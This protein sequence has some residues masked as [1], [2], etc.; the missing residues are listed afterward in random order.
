MRLFKSDNNE[1]ITSHLQQE[2]V[3]LLKQ[4]YSEESNVTSQRD[5]SSLEI[6]PSGD[7]A[8]VGMCR[9]EVTNNKQTQLH[10]L[11]FLMK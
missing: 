9:T 8:E 10:K 5:S 6:L 1:R 11:K 3:L 2:N 4:A 7:N